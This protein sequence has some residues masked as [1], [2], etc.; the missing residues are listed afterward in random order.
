MKPQP[1]SAD[2][3][4]A[5]RPCSGRYGLVFLILSLGL[6]MFVFGKAVTGR[7][8]LAPLDI[9]WDLFEHYRWLNP[10]GDGIPD[11]QW[12]IDVFDHELPRQYSIYQAVRQGEFPWWD[13][14]TD[15]GRPLAA[16][17]HIGGTD[18]IRLALYAVLPFELA[19]NWAKICSSLLYGLGAYLLLR[20]LGFPEWINVT[21]ALT[22]QFA[23]NH[24]FAQTPLC[25]M[26]TFA[27]YGLLWWLWARLAAGFRWC[28]VSWSGL[29]CACIIL[30]GNQQTD[31]C[32]AIFAL[33]FLIG[34]GTAN[35]AIWRTLFASISGS[36]LLGA[37]ISLP[38]LL[39]QFELLFLC[40]RTP[41][42][43]GARTL[44]LTGLANCSALFPWAMGTF[45]SLDVGKLFGETQ[46]GF[47][48]YIGSAGIALAAGGVLL[49]LLAKARPGFLR[50]AV[51]LVAVYEVIC[52]TPLLKV[53]YLRSS[54]LAVLGLTLLCAYTLHRLAAGDI[55]PRVRRFTRW[56]CLV[57]VGAWLLASL[58]ALVIFPK[59][60]PR[61]QAA[62]DRY[63][64][65]RERNYPPL[66]RFRRFQVA[67]VPREIS[68]LNPETVAAAAGALGL[69]FVLRPS[70]AG[71]ARRRPWVWPA[72]LALNLAPLLLFSHRFTA[73][74]PVEFW[75]SLLHGDCEQ[76]RLA[77][78]LG[79]PYRL[80]GSP[81]F[82]Y[83]K[84]YP[85]ALAH[86]YRV[87][88]T[89]GYSSFPM[90]PVL[91]ETRELGLDLV[92]S[93]T[94]PLTPS[95]DAADASFV[96]APPPSGTSRFQWQPPLRRSVKVLRES[97]NQIT[98]EVAAGHAGVLVRTDR[99]YPG[100]RVR[101]PRTIPSRVLGRWL[102]ALDVP[103]P[104]TRITFAYSPRF[105]SLSLPIALMS[106][107]GCLVTG[108][109]AL[110]RAPTLA[111]GR[112]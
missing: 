58:V 49:C 99:Y 64:L 16:E 4:T 35:R 69:F 71:A 47:Y 111:D 97:L 43:Q 83:Q 73:R 112:G 80:D 94:G 40:G 110:F 54:D 75:R 65:E 52:L 9:A 104:Q 37:L 21:C 59:V 87:H 39:A 76:S 25:G 36:L 60:Q 17:G 79:L 26:S 24:A 28:Y 72:L 30:A 98:I 41:K 77:A 86:L 68:W 22:Y 62:V 19:Y 78:A 7:S 102:L 12:L 15:S 50:T 31:A 27:Y 90:P 74:Q 67:N 46:A 93:D 23:A 92:S 84:V 88:N 109:A 1:A 63:V 13:P 85:G 82:R 44:W 101:E 38:V 32:L 56:L 51:L 45:R 96:L 103:P 57:C 107:A 10:R 20:S 55:E 42:F 91:S 95:P 8:L 61:I 2:S 14:Y 100:W 108:T 66:L 70:G 89:D 34:Y 53:F 29:L 6:A 33:C 3:G 18:P 11:N 48:V 5:A 81:G 106:L 105:L